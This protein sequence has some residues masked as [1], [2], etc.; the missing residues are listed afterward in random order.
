MNKCREFLIK[1]MALFDGLLLITVCTSGAF[2]ANQFLEAI[3]TATPLRISKQKPSQ[4][5]NL[6]NKSANPELCNQAESLINEANMLCRQWTADS[7]QEAIRKYRKAISV[8]RIC[9]Q[10]KREAE[11]TKGICEVY[12]VLGDYPQ[13]LSYADKTA[14]IIRV[15]GQT[16]EQIESLNTLSLLHI[17]LGEVPLAA[18]EYRRAY[19]L[20]KTIDFPAGQAQALNRMGL[21]AFVTGDLDNALTHF[22]QALT[23]WQS[24]GDAKGQAEAAINLGYALGNGGD[25]Y[26]ALESYN[27]SLELC[28]NVGDIKGIALALT[29]IGGINNSLGEKQKA[30][31]NH[32]QAVDLFRRIGDKNGEAAALNGIGYVYDSS[33]DKE[34]ALKSYLHALDLYTST[35]NRRAMTIT[36]GYVG[37]TLFSMGEKVKALTYLER[38]LRSSQLL[39][40]IR[41]EAYALKDIGASHEANGNRDLALNY[42]QKSLVLSRKAG[43]RRGQIY[44]LNRIGN[45][46]KIKGE[47]Q[48]S[49]GRYNDA[50][51]LARALE[52]HNEIA[53][54]LYNIAL[55][56]RDLGKLREAGDRIKES[57]EVIESLRKRIFG[58]EIRA[59]FLSTVHQYYELYIDVL[60]QLDRLHGTSGNTSLVE[61]AFWISEQA[62]SRSLLDTLRE[63]K[64]DLRQG[65]STELLD[66]ERRLQELLNR[67]AERYM[68]LKETN[69]SKNLL[70]SLQREIEEYVTEYKEV[71]AQVKARSPAFAALAEIITPSLS[72]VQKQILDSDSLLLEFSLGEPRSYLWVISSQSVNSFTLSG[73]SEIESLSR[74]ICDLLKDPGKN[75]TS[76]PESSKGENATAN[77]RY[78]NLASTLSK[79]LLGPAKKLLDNKRLIIVPDGALHYLPFAALPD[80]SIEPAGNAAVTPLMVGHEIVI[81]PS[82]STIALIRDQVKDRKSAPKAIAIL[83]DPVYEI[84]DSRISSENDS[85]QR[86]SGKGVAAD[87]YSA[88]LV[89]SIA[90]VTGAQRGT[91]FRRLPFAAQ[92]AET[93]SSLVSPDDCLKA[94][95]F[96]ATRELAMSSK[97]A[98]YRIIHFATHG[99]LNSQTPELSGIVLSLVDR[100]KQSRDGFLRL[101]EIYQ[102]KLS[103]ELVVLSACQTGL[104]KEIRGEG[105]VGLTRG[106]MYAGAPRVISTLWEID[107]R[108]ST[109]LMKYFYEGMFGSKRYRPGEALRFAQ[110]EMWKRDRWNS[111]YYW[112]AFRLEGEWR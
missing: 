96:D 93:I 44:V 22:K 46:Y 65:V 90:E 17:E 23:V 36:A 99:L 79:L 92:E 20:S 16:R 82:V 6:Q 102:L 95:A 67:K 12:L 40:D 52:D 48:A 14:R 30:L 63:V 69:K 89:R 76:G 72:E 47:L 32:R 60:M 59:G 10:R 87:P 31:E 4:S 34:L 100:Q 103:A 45:I 73:R 66:R 75:I 86:S 81:L 70:T 108:A 3:H 80:P 27:K 29:A 2:A 15:L 74:N 104:G 107:D 77:F 9:R 55:V 94:V 97:L 51:A 13:A 18:L 11:A 49:L 1:S 53:A 5:I 28:R 39:K 112:A 7:F 105:L 43:D 71:Q 61:K 88:D 19:N 37:N 25:T 8:A 42:Y 33:G 50:L 62:R 91:L 85:G 64:L 58:A 98:D 83:A 106:F 84:N 78:Q 38:K 109:E 21:G 111:P 101:N 57:I 35:G 54:T 26:K 41:I 56:D 24:I 68:K 110:I